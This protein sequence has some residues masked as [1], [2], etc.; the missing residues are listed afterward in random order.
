MTT[1]GVSFQLR[2]I[3]AIVATM[4]GSGWHGAGEDFRW[5][6]P[7]ED[8]AGPMVEAGL[9]GTEIF[10][11]VDRQVGAFREVLAQQAVGR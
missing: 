8:L 6:S 5:C 1:K 2:W 7:A 10:E 11:A 9:D 4:T 3:R